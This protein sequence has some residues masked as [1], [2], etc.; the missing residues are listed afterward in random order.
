MISVIHKPGCKKSFTGHV[1]SLDSI[2][3]FSALKLSLVKRW[4]QNEMNMSFQGT[5][6]WTVYWWN[7]E[8]R[9]DGN[10]HAQLSRPNSMSSFVI[11]YIFCNLCQ[12]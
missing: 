8:Y 3:I 12:N 5:D 7:K 11:W 1:P 6:E 10:G 4:M 9:S 2:Y